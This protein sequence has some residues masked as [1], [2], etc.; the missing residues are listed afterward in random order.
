MC[1]EPKKDIAT[2]KYNSENNSLFGKY[3]DIIGVN[4][5]QLEL[6]PTTQK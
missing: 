2:E 5:Q 1:E 6:Q 3:I 4:S